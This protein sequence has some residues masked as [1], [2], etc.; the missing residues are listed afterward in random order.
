LVEEPR[1]P[2]Q[3]ALSL[4]CCYCGLSLTDA[5]F[6]ID[7]VTPT[8]RGGSLGRDNL[9]VCCMRFNE[10]KGRLD[11]EEFSA[12]L[13]LLAAWPSEARMDVLMRLRAGGGAAVNGC[14][15]WPK[16]TCQENGTISSCKKRAR[17]IG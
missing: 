12:L 14:Q 16:R 6:A 3:E 11:D 10:I 2:V 5:N 9:R 13:A 8:S 1:S 15:H 7:H 17:K 4:P